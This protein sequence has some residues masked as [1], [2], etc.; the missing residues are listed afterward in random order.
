MCHPETIHFY[1]SEIVSRKAAEPPCSTLQAQ[2]LLCGCTYIWQY[3]YIAFPATQELTSWHWQNKVK[4][5]FKITSLA[6]HFSFILIQILHP[7][8]NSKSLN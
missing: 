3:P 2:R 1:Q 6:L 7:Q 5:P 4:L 8:I